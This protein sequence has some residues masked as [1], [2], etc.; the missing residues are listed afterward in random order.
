VNR[1]PN[2]AE[3]HRI[4]S[5]ENYTCR[6][7]RYY[8]KYGM[9]LQIDHIIP[10][11]CGGTNSFDNFQCLCSVC[12][13]IKGAKDAPKLQIQTPIALSNQYG[14]VLDIVCELRKKFYKEIH[15][16]STG[17]FKRQEQTLELI[18]VGEWKPVQ[19]KRLGEAIAKTF[20]KRKR[21]LDIEEKLEE[22][23]ELVRIATPATIKCVL[24]Y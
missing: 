13:R 21:V 17:W 5:K 2:D 12:N 23:H 7:C 1:M 14:T 9:G 20:V 11:A 4:F 8:D 24:A 22:Y 3:R 19:R 16:R 18:N 6:A 10:K 15:P